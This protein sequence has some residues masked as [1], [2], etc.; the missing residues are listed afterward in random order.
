MQNLDDLKKMIKKGNLNIPEYEANLFSCFSD[1]FFD[2]TNLSLSSILHDV[3]SRFSCRYSC[4][5][6]C[7]NG[8]APK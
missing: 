6:G 3:F 8:D 7:S 5:A 2:G 1:I 4:Y